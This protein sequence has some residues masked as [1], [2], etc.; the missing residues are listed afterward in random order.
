MKKRML[1]TNRELERLH[2]I[3]KEYTELTIKFLKANEWNKEHVK[4]KL[5]KLK[6]ERDLILTKKQGM[7]EDVI[8]NERS[9]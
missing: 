4:M 3:S 7:W 2:E 5:L 8:K 1:I 6:N 9:G